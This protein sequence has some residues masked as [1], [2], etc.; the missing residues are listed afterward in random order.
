MVVV[1]VVVSLKVYNDIDADVTSNKSALL[2]LKLSHQRTAMQG[3][4]FRTRIV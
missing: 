1:A 3:S 2:L 4:I